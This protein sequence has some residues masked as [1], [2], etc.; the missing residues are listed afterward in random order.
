MMVNTVMQ[1]RTRYQSI[2]NC[3]LIILPVRDFYYLK[4]QKS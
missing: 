4:R 2:N 1:T 3:N